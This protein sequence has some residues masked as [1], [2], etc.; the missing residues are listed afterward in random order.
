M[1]LCGVGHL[2]YCTLTRAHRAILPM[3]TPSLGISLR[4]DVEATMGHWGSPLPLL[5]MAAV[6]LPL[7]QAGATEIGSVNQKEFSGAI[8]ILTSGDQEELHYGTAV[9]SYETVVTDANSTTVL[10]FKDTSALQVGSNSRV[11]LDNFVYDPEPDAGQAV[12]KLGR[13]ACRLITGYTQHEDKLTIKTPTLSMVVR[14]T[15]LLIY[16]LSDGTTEVN[17]VEGE[18]GALP[19]RPP[20][21]LVLG[22]G[23]AA[24]VD[25]QCTVTVGVARPA[26]NRT[27]PPSMPADLAGLDLEPAAGPI[28]PA[29]EELRD[30]DRRDDDSGGVGG[31]TTSASTSGPS[32]AT[33]PTGP[34]GSNQ[35][36]GHNR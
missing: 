21:D 15:H 33:G 8:G 26:G 31:K 2:S 23:Q 34:Q 7:Q 25:P 14:G 12:I 10:L 24:T 35:H 6:V 20:A 19:C 16:V 11:V 4:Q 13:G 27:E 29:I 32:G 1:L 3:A 28:A 5:I 22:A 18:V 30:N 36:H 17:V 9:Y